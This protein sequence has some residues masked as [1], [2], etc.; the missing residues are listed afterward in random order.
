MKTV[1]NNNSN[2][3]VAADFGHDD[4]NSNSIDNDDL[5]LL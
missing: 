4:D 3:D 1:A 5:L 2:T